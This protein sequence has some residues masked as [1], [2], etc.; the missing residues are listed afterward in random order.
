MHRQIDRARQQRFL[1][2]L[3]EQPLAA[4][5]AQ[6]TVLD[7]VARG[8]DRHDLDCIFGDAMR[9]GERRP[10]HARLRQCERAAARADAQNRGLRHV[11]SQCYADESL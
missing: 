2:L 5:L 3:G 8:T 1:D 4:G 10:R 6:R 7:A 9:R 11:T